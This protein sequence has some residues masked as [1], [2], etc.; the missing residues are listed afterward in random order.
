[1]AGWYFAFVMVGGPAFLL[2]TGLRRWLKQFFLPRVCFDRSTGL[3]TLGRGGIRGKRPLADIIGVQLFQTLESHLLPGSQVM[4]LTITQLNLVLDDPQQPRLHITDHGRLEVAQQVADFLQIPL[5]N[6]VPAQTQS[7][8]AGSPMPAVDFSYLPP[9]RTTVPDAVVT[10]P[11]DQYL[12]IRSEWKSWSKG[13]LWH[14]ASASWLPLL[15][16]VLGVIGFAVVVEKVLVPVLIA[17]PIL[18]LMALFRATRSRASFDRETGLMSLGRFGRPGKRPL[19]S[20]VAIQFIPTGLSHQVNLVLDNASEPRLNLI[21]HFVYK[22]THAISDAELTGTRQAAVHL[23]EFLQIPLLEQAPEQVGTVR[24]SSA[25]VAVLLSPAPLGKATIPSPAVVRQVNTDRIVVRSRRQVNW[26]VCAGFLFA[27]LC[28]LPLVLLVAFGR[29]PAKDRSWA[30]VA[31]SG[32][33]LLGLL[34]FAFHPFLVNR[35][36]FDRTRKVMTLG[37]LGLRGKRA[38]A[39]VVAIQVISGGL[40]TRFSFLK[41]CMGGT[42]ETDGVVTYQVNLVLDDPANPRLNLIS[43]TDSTRARQVGKQLADFFE[44]SLVDQISLAK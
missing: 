1:L 23:A 12:L 29:V 24:T 11:R 6:H 19:T 39:D 37:W 38:L 16:A 35:L 33:S 34:P 36:C 43:D 41:F 21:D 2:L 40:S 7:S 3:L 42:H 18:L 14:L 27:C 44:V 17:L 8:S 30:E 9:G 26:W 10:R 5:L 4:G 32:L 22:P 28:F 25:T 31:A 15:L 20:V 13:R